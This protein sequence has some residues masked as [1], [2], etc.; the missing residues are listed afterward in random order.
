MCR[1]FQSIRPAS[2]AED[3]TR[4]RGS[5]IMHKIPISLF[6]AVLILACGLI[7]DAKAES[8]KR[9]DKE[10]IER[11]LN[12]ASGRDSAYIATLIGET[13]GR[14]YIEYAT[15]IHASSFLSK[16]M[17][18]IVY[19][20]PLSELTEEQFDM[21]KAYKEKEANLDLQPR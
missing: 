16:G 13:H 10:D 5:A 3:F 17:K 1:T 4:N 19:W 20:L 7:G 2:L 15:A 21:F 9:A 14:V 6:V 12:A 11:L 8:I 18:Y